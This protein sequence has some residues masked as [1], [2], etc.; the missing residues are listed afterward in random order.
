MVWR[1]DDRCLGDRRVREQ[2][3]LHVER[4]DPVAGHDDDVVVAGLESEV[5]VVVDT[6]GVTREVPPAVGAELLLAALGFVEV[7]GEPGEWAGG[8]VEGDPSHL[9]GGGGL[10]SVLLQYGAGP[11]RHGLSHGSWLERSLEG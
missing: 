7:A 3:G 2:H 9:A 8:E 11:A 6:A 4:A 5:A 10:V 1:G